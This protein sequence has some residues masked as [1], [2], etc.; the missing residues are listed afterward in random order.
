M[1][2]PT[3]T[4]KMWGP[5]LLTTPLI[6]PATHMFLQWLEHCS[7]VQHET[8]QLNVLKLGVARKRVLCTHMNLSVTATSWWELRCDS[9]FANPRA[10]LAASQS[11]SECPGQ[12]GFLTSAATVCLPTGTGSCWKR[13]VFFTN[14]YLHLVT[15]SVINIGQGRKRKLS[16]AAIRI[17]TDI[18]Y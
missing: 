13:L 3:S 5:A 4:W 11:F 8:F 16:S 6:R 7:S 14:S 2:L 1:I 10:V 9:S 18:P 17:L 15:E 12:Q